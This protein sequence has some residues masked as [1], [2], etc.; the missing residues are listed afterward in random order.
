MAVSSVSSSSSIYGNRNIITGLASGMDTESMIENA[1]A[2]YKLKISKLN[3]KSTK[4]GWQME[5]YRSIIDKMVN[6][7]NKYTSYLSDTNLLSSSFFNNAVTTT[8]NGKNADKISATG[9]TNSDIQFLGVKQLAKA[10]T[11]TV[12]AGGVFGAGGTDGKITASE[13][14][15]NEVKELSTVSGTLTLGYGGGRTFDLTFDDLDVYENP[16]EL[17]AAI[18]S[19]LN[20]IQTTNS[21][22]ELVSA[23]SMIRVSMKDGNIVFSDNQGAG[24]SVTI[25]SATGKIKDTL[26]IDPAEKSNT[27]KVDGKTLVDKSATAGDYLSG[28]EFKVTLDG[29]TKTITMPT[30]DKESGTAE[31]DFVTGIQKELDKAFGAGK[32]TVSNNGTT[33]EDIA[34][35]PAADNDGKIKLGFSV[36]GGS[37]LAISSSK[38]GIGKALGLESDSATTYFDVSKTLKDLKTADGKPLLESLQAVGEL[39]GVGAPSLQ[40]NG[41]YLD[42]AGK[43]VDK[44]GYRLQLDEDGNVVTDKDGNAVRMKTYELNINGTKIGEYS[45]ETA[46]ETVMNG[47]NSNSEAGVRVSYSKLTNQ[48]QFTTSQ[49]GEANGIEIKSDLKDGKGSNLAAALFGTV[50]KDYNGNVT[51]GTAGAKYEAGQDAKFT[52]KV[53]GDTFT[54][55]TRSSNTFDVDGLSVTLKGTFEA[56]SSVTDNAVSFTTTSDADKIVDAIKSFVEDYNEMATEVKNAYS[57]LPAKKS[58]GSR[59]EPLTDEEL[60]SWTDSAIEAHNEKAK[61][62]ILFGDSNLTSLYNKLRS[63]ITANGGDMRSIGLTTSYSNGMTTL[64]LDEKALRS[65]LANNPDSVRDVFTKSIEGGASSDGLMTTLKKQLD[66]YASTTGATKGILIEYAGSARAPTSLN[67]NSLQRQLNNFDTQIEKLQSK[68][69]DQIDRYTQ[70]FSQLEQLIAEMNSQSS[71]LMGLMG[72][73]SSGY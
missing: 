46:L 64:Q 70:K 28:K 37:T 6:F 33:A 18:Q 63:A 20:G 39:K 56:D 65:A 30:Y 22:G 53:N 43:L 15:L 40:K 41:T 45:E 5:A 1:V 62:G 52:M 44:E 21:K 59:Y 67:A 16:K 19:K 66:T 14:D 12:P 47:I 71:T 27:L 54:D 60:E 73:G 35:D 26:G 58:N 23:G 25:K 13:I 61:Q 55:I 17:Q 24:N 49:T 8:T 57:T 7:S 31:K 9:K 72:G 51:T 3:Q 48:F 38:S 42:S 68:M 10:A 2:G 29:V 32:I 4:V 34:K 69:S 11:F 50:T 36:N